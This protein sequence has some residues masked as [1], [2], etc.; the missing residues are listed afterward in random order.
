MGLINFLRKLGIFR[1]GTMKAKYKNTKE[2]PLEFQMSGV[3]D[4]KKD[5]I[6]SK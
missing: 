3:Y 6:N 1:F 4:E 5:I 2:R